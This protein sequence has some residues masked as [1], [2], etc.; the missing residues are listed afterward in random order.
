[1]RPLR[2]ITA[3]GAALVLAL[4]ACGTE[5]EAAPALSTTAQADA[6][7]TENALRARLDDVYRIVI[8]GGQW[9]KGYDYLSPRCQTK[10]NR[11]EV[12][13][14]LKA[15]YGPESGRDF[16]G[17]PTYVITVDGDSASVVTQASDGKG[18]NAPK[19]WTFVDGQW[20]NDSC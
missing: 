13:A 4:S 17:E 10:H 7:G 8:Q 12:E 15:E 18:S 20:S 2:A 16:S 6:S 9:A 19:T 5:Q 3:V 11:T 1:M 14:A